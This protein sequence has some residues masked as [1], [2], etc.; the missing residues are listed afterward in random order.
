MKEQILKQLLDT[1]KGLDIPVPDEILNRITI[2]SPDAKL[3]DFATN[4][5]LI[6]AKVSGQK[7]ADL[8]RMIVEKIDKSRFESVEVAGAGFINFRLKNDELIK[9]LNPSPGASRHPLPQ[10]ERENLKVLLEYF[11]PNIAKPL[12]IGHLE[13]AIIGDALKRLML[14]TGVKVESDTHMGNWGTQFGYLIL[15]YKKHERVDEKLYAQLNQAAEKDPSI[16]ESA[17][18]EFAKLE[19]GDSDN[20]KIWEEIVQVSVKEF[21]KINDLLGVL[22]FDHHWPESF[23]EDKMPAVLDALKGKGLLVGS[24]GAQIVNLENQGLGVAI[25]KKSDGSTTYLLRDL[26]TFVFA[27][28]QGFAKHLYV[29]DNRQSHHYHQLF[30]ILKLMGEMQDEE[31]VH[32]DYGFISFKGQALSTRKGNMILAYDVIAEAEDKVGKIIQEKNPDLPNKEQ[33]TKVVAR[34]ALK[35]FI[36]KHNRHS[37]IEFD[38]EEV[39]DF[40]GNS[41]PYLQY[42]YARLASILRKERWE[43]GKGE[44]EFVVSPTEHEL[45]LKILA[46]DDAITESLKD[47]LPNLLANFLYELAGLI[48]KFYH[49]SPVMKEQNLDLKNFRLMLIAKAKQALGTGLNLL[50]I[51]SLEEM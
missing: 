43:A 16:H 24:Q 28:Q 11:Q 37:D 20:R 46:L 29:V 9:E 25:I 51:E 39:L 50:G 47:Y 23:Y 3:G 35:Y 32:I 2:T 30:A 5:A 45:M 7:P 18:A 17:K 48:N 36:L 14:Y 42:A 31:G 49:E 41:G 34:G 33:A 1:I 12:H 21:L 6:L 40:E 15:I 10:G 4:A 22:P 26:A 27:K 13:T 44:G 19:Q 8:A 38:W